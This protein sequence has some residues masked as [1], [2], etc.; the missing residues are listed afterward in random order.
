MKFDTFG[1]CLAVRSWRDTL[2]GERVKEGDIV[3]VR[4][5]TELVGISP[6]AARTQLWLLFSGLNNDSMWLLGDSIRTNDVR[7]D[8]RR[9]SIP[10]DRLPNSPSLARIRDPADAYQPFLSIDE[11]N[12][13]GGHIP[14]LTYS[15]PIDVHGL[16]YDKQTTRFL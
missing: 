3:Y 15:A 16:V 1:V 12:L 13:T 11:D 2:G 10:L 5:V 9:Y 14:F 8:K 4:R 7:Y 6:V